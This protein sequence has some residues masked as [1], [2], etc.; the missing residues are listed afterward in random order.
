MNLSIQNK[1][2]LLHDLLDEQITYKSISVNECRHIKRLVQSIVVNRHI[3][4]DLK[5]I[6]PEI[7]YY[8]IKGEHAQS[9][10]NHITDHEHRIKRWLY[11]L[12]QV[13]YDQ[14]S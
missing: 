11:L 7:Y 4:H 1:L 10:L 12:H 8:G 6:L 13:K 14:T 3:S 9:L 5:N 2:T